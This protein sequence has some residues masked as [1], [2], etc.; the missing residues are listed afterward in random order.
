MN[1][2]VN[3]FDEYTRVTDE[4]KKI[5]PT[6]YFHL[7]LSPRTSHNHDSKI[8]TPPPPPLAAPTRCHWMPLTHCRQKHHRRTLLTYHHRMPQHRLAASSALRR[9]A[10]TR[11]RRPASVDS[12]LAP[13]CPDI[14]S[15]PNSPPPPRL[16]AAGLPLPQGL[17][18]VP[19]SPSAWARRATAGPRRVGA[20]PDASPPALSRLSAP[21]HAPEPAATSGQGDFLKKI[22]L[23]SPCLSVICSL[24]F[25]TSWIWSLRLISSLTS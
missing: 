16:G 3:L 13:A 22:T 19:T 21:S 18:S 7:S 5:V 25:E 4:L 17:C 11:H 20:G 9:P 6:V 8:L 2:Y 10:L 24:R 15:S 12:A 14:A 1:I 23:C